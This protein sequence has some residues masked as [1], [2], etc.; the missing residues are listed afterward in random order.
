ML[1]SSLLRISFYYLKNP[2]FVILIES[3]ILFYLF[4]KDSTIC[5]K[6]KKKNK[7]L[8]TTKR[9]LGSIHIYRRRFK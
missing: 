4:N 2:I 8:K 7:D 9:S 5:K 1:S 3:G 6:K